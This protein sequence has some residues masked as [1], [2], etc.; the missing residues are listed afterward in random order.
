MTSDIG[1]I[2]SRFYLRIED[3]NIVGL[4][5]SI[6]DEMMD[7]WMKSAL[8]VPYVRRLFDKY[9]VDN[10]LGEIE[11]ELKFPVSDDEDK[12]FVEEVIALGMV[13][14]WLKPRYN[15]T[16]NTSQFFSN[17]EQKFYSQANHMAE[18]R[19]MYHQAKLEQRKLIRDRGYIYNEYISKT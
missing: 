19:E 18:L 13:V 17:S 16:L 15:S 7:G 1:E 8:S 5:E 2:Y 9:A 6:V 11:Y 10:D 14:Q 3:Y 4:D 12:D